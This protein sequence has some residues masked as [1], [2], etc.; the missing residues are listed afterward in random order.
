[1]GEAEDKTKVMGRKVAL[2]LIII[3]ATTVLAYYGKMNADVGVVFGAAIAS[4][5]YALRNSG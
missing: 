1:M 3:T 2:T 4:F 5:N